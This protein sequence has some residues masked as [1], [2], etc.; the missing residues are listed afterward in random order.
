MKKTHDLL[1]TLFWGQLLLAALIY[2]GCEYLNVDISF[3]TT[4]SEPT[5][6]VVSTIMILATLALL[7][8]ALRLFK[9]RKVHA[10]LISLRETALHKWGVLRL[11][12]LGGLLLINTL[13]YYAFG[14]EPSFGYLAVVVL[15]AMPFIYPSM[16]RCLTEVEEVS[17]ENPDNPESP[18]S[19][20][21]PVTPETPAQ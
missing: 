4:A 13:L 12:L 9:L 21:A 16:A 18:E 8:L 19:P 2:V 11:L 10:E 5:R 6:Y 1:M 20:E 17:P 14:F 7:P 15:L 3:L